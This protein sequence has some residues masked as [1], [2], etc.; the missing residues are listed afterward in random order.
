MLAAVR[1]DD[2]NLPLLVHVAGA[3]L[4]MGFLVAAVA[5]F[6]R[7]ANGGDGTADAAALTRVGLRAVLLGA[8]PAYIVMRGGGEWLASTEDLTDPTWLNIGY[9]V[10]DP[11]LVVLLATAVVAQRAARRTRAGGPASRAAVG[12]TLLLVVAFAVVVWAMTA[13]PS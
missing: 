3:M 12:L 7:A 6:A 5:S 11:A 8:L 13:K 9:I 2:W 10:S 1:P 4:L